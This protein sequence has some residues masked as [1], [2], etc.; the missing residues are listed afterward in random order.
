[1]TANKKDDRSHG[2]LVPVA[3]VKTGIYVYSSKERFRDSVSNADTGQLKAA[4]AVFRGS[5]E[6]R[7]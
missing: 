5:R 2:R 1:M 3:G 4:F 7:R 6:K